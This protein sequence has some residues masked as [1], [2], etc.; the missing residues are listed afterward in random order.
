MAVRAAIAYALCAK[1]ADPEVDV[2][3]AMAIVDRH[4]DI[5]V[6]R[7]LAVR[8]TYGILI[9]ELL[10][11]D[12]AWT[13]QHLDAIFPTDTDQAAY[14]RAAWA[15]LVE[16]QWQTADTWTLLNSVF[17]RAIDDLD[18]TATDQYAVARATNLGHHLLRRYWFGTLTL[19][20]Q[21]Q[22][23]QRFY[24]NVPADVAA[25]LTRSVGMNLPKDE[26]LETAL[27]GR[28]KA[29]WKYRIDSVDLA[30]SDPRELAD[31]DRWFVSGA[32]D[33]TWSLQQLL[34]VL[35]RCRDVELDP[36][37]LRRLAELSATHPL[38]CLAII[39]RWLENEPDYWA[40]SRRLESLRTI[41]EAGTAA[42]APEAALAKK[43]VS[44]LLELH[45]IDLRDSLT[46]PTAV[47][48]PTAE[49]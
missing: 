5:H 27:S 44:V 6:E 15:A 1:R 49:S 9:P 45:G 39:D 24:R 14:W 22:L 16:R 12:S 32:F 28:L 35:K 10:M 41:L 4:L 2:S 13:A 38:P 17:G 8:A 18:P 48:P 7:S 46:P 19:T 31:F 11:L 29:L 20:D 43:I 23:L 37:T 30:G 34:A 36:Q 40:L 42:G 3:S 33:D 26:P 25:Q 21:D 47:S